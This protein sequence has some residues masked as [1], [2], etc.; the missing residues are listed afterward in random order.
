ML[1]NPP[2]QRCSVKHQ[3]GRLKQTGL[4]GK[5]EAEAEQKKAT[6]NSTASEIQIKRC[7]IATGERIFSLFLCSKCIQALASA[8]CFVC[9]WHETALND[10]ISVR[11]YMFFFKCPHL[12][13]SNKWWNFSNI[14]AI[15]NQISLWGAQAFQEDK[16]VFP[17]WVLIKR[18]VPPLNY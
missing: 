4:S 2:L 12:I 13:K 8:T 3:T 16:S 10:H 18:S 17:Q 11:N 9:C 7:F 15:R 6:M 1:W 5:K 14:A